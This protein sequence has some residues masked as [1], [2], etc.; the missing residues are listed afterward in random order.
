V[1]DLDGQPVEGATVTFSLVPSAGGAGASFTG[2]AAQAT[3]LT[4]AAGLATSP[5]FQANTVAGAFTATATIAGVVEPLHFVLRNLAGRPATIVAGV[6]ATESAL[7][8]TRFPVRLAVT[9][10]DAKGNAVPGAVVTFTAPKHG[11]SGHFGRRG[12]T[13]RVVTNAAGVAAAPALTANAKPGGYVVV[14][15]VPGAKRPAAFALV[16]VRR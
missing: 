1:V 11:A 5:S 8:G 3:V 7:T 14:A 10:T 15:T 9:V 4:D 2:G 13:V 16:N 6:A 12:H